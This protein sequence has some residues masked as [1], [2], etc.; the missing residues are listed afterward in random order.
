MTERLGSQKATED[1]DRWIAAAVADARVPAPARLHEQ[2]ERK[3]LR[4]RRRTPWLIGAGALAATAALV[5][6]AWLIVRP[7][8]PPAIAA[9]DAIVR[10][11]VGDHLRILVAQHPLE[12]E[13][14]DMHQVKPW[15]AGRLEFV[16]PVSFLG[17][18]DFPLR[19]G[20]VAVFLG[21]RAAAF[22]YARRLHVISLFAYPDPS[23]SSDQREETMRSGFHIITWRTGDIGMALI[24]DVN[25][26]DL[27]ALE[28][29]LH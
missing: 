11:A 17:D 27:R 4:P 23:P 14:S 19:G 21:R 12:V 16:P 10:E 6:I 20:Q 28:A 2:L 7:G 9:N 3:Y 1:A 22:V 29:K 25:W 24:S 26:E 13:S 18:D 5:V 15:F 8:A